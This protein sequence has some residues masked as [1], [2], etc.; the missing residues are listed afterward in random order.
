MKDLAGK[1]A[2]I[3]GAGSGF[4]RELARIGA[5]AAQSGCRLARRFPTSANRRGP[6]SRLSRSGLS[7]KAAPLHPTTT[8]FVPSRGSNGAATALTSRRQ[9]PRARQNPNCS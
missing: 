4:G 1:V 3:T 5:N 6:M 9:S 2:V 8:G 7:W